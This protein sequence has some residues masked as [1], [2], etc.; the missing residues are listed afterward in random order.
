MS[1]RSRA[2]GIAILAALAINGCAATETSSS[3]SG[4][5]VTQ[6]SSASAGAPQSNDSKTSSAA[7]D[8]AL[9]ASVAAPVTS[10]PSADT[11]TEPP[12]TETG[13]A[14]DRGAFSHT[15]YHASWAIT[16]STGN[17]TQTALRDGDSYSITQDGAVPLAIRAVGERLQ[18]CDSSSCNTNENA[19]N[20]DHMLRSIKLDPAYALGITISDPSSQQGDAAF[21]EPTICL[22]GSDAILDSTNTVTACYLQDTDLLVSSATTDSAGTVLEKIDL[23]KLSGDVS[24]EAFDTLPGPIPR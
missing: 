4:R 14:V 2:L 10:A 18:V 3:T 22:T 5:A 13:T 7:A 1:K 15:H 16:N 21:G 23:T 19:T 6:D 12:T 11:P 24:P 17:S 8:S 9:S 20:T